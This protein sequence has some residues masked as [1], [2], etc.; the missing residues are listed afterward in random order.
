TDNRMT[1][2]DAATR[3]EHAID[4]RAIFASIPDPTCFPCMDAPL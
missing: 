2:D 1:G 3:H 4:I